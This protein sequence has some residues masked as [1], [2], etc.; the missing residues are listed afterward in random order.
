MEL[1]RLSLVFVALVSLVTVVRASRAKSAS[2]LLLGGLFL[3][4]SAVGYLLVGD[5]AGP[6]LFGAWL[7]L[8]M[9]PGLSMRGA[10]VALHRQR[11]ALAERL[12]FV[13][14]VLHPARAGREGLA[15]LAVLS[16]IERGDVAR[17]CAILRGVVQA[18]GEG[19]VDAELDL[20]RFEER[21]DELSAAVDAITAEQVARSP[22]LVVAGMRA[23]AELGRRD[24]LVA[25]FLRHER[26][27]SSEA[28]AGVRTIALLHLFASTGRQGELARLLATRLAHLSAELV[29]LWSAVV[30]LVAGESAARARLQA[31]AEAR[32]GAVR[33]S[34]RVYLERGERL[35][36]EPLP[37]DL[38][39][40][41]ERLAKRLEQEAR[42]VVGDTTRS[43]PVL[44]WAIALVLLAVFALS[45][46]RGGSTKAEVLFELGALWPPSV[47]V[48]GELYR[49][50]AALVLHFGPLHLAMN[51]AALLALA[52]FV[53]RSLGRARFSL[54]YLGSGLV[55]STLYVAWM[56][57]GGAKPGLM[58]GASGCI[59]GMVGASAAVLARGVRREKALVAKRRLYGMVALVALQTTF[60]LLTP[61]VS[62]FAHAVGAVTG[63]VLASLLSHESSRGA[64]RGLGRP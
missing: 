22:A 42:F 7:V 25:W 11:Y 40:E 32:D 62:L 51:V 33:R 30:A 41:V 2:H 1:D 34:A 10:V 61:N 16:A 19:A 13:A 15:R 9:V 59:M 46:L 23:L 54:V 17:A 31:L 58:V 24:D 53:E 20:L 8:V 26:H 29:E 37:G 35:A 43:K 12:A 56:A 38:V 3:A 60:D 64:P 5:A 21:W 18:K 44:T 52:P 63:F 14:Y 45:E 39:D 48:D 27:V 6:W 36:A 49:L 50:V 28:L 57:L 4:A 47:L 55:G